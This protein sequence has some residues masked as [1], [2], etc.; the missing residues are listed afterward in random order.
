MKLS[1]GCMIAAT[2]WAGAAYAQTFQGLP[3]QTSSAAVSPDDAVSSDDRTPLNQPTRRPP[4]TTGMAAG[5][6]GP[7]LPNPNDP[8]KSSPTVPDAGASSPPA[9]KQ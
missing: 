2:L 4:T 7:F 9:E 3:G 5:T 6:P 8:T 1:F